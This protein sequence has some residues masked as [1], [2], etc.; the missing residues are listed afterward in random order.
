MNGD[1]YMNHLIRQL[2]DCEKALV[3][4]FPSIVQYI[5]H[6]SND[7]EIAQLRANGWKIVNEPDI[8]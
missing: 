3:D 5:V 8:P 4:M 7:E 1:D 6:T 2:Q